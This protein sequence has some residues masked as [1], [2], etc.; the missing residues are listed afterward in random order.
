VQLGLHVGPEQLEQ[1][2]SQKLLAVCRIYSSRWTALSGLSGTR[3]A[4]PH[5]DLMC[6]GESIPR[7]T[8]S[9][10]RTSRN[11]GGMDCGKG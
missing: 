3:C 2:L 10:Q 4:L 5:R 6:Q 11:K 7:R 1:G 9:A 8:S